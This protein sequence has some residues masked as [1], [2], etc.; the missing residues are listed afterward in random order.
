VGGGGESLTQTITQRHKTEPSRSFMFDILYMFDGFLACSCF[1]EF[2]I[3]ELYILS[4]VL[5][6][7]GNMTAK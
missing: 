4:H 6:W 2:N 7:F 1:T 5:L 3:N